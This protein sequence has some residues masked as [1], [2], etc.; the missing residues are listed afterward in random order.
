MGLN[1]KQLIIRP[2]E[3]K[4][5]Q[6]IIRNRNSRAYEVFRAKII[7]LI[8]SGCTYKGIAWQLSCSTDTVRRWRKRWENGGVEVNIRLVF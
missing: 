6:M 7:L 2:T 8:A 3:R 4:Y 5:L 1:V